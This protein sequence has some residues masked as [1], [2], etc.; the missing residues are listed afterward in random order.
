[1]PQGQLYLNKS[2]KKNF[3]TKIL[4]NTKY[5][6]I[7]NISAIEYPCI[8]RVKNHLQIESPQVKKATNNKICIA[9]PDLYRKN[10]PNFD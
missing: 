2:K 3:Q 5:K 4:Y 8:L 9:Y 1:M 7:Q 10:F 6:F